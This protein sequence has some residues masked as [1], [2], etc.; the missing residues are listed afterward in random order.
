M[1]KRSRNEVTIRDVAAAAKVSM[2]T[3]SNVLNGRFGRMRVQTRQRVEHAM[4]VLRYRPHAVARNLRRSERLS[5]GLLFIDDDST[6]ITHPGHSHVVDGL[7]RYL[8]DRGY[9]LTLQGLNPA[10]LSEALPVRSV[11]TD[12]LCI[13]QSGPPARRMRTLVAL[14]GIAQPCV[15]IHENK[16]SVEGDFCQVREDD[17]A[18]GRL[19]AQHLIDRGCRNILMLLPTTIWASMEERA[20]GCK[21]I[22]NREKTTLSVLR[23][24]SSL[25]EQAQ[26]RLSA[27]LDGNEPPDG[28]IA[29]N[30]Q[31]GIAALRVLQARGLAVPA[32]VRV[33]GFNAFELWKYSN[34]RLTTIRTPAAALGVR[35]GEE[36]VR[37]LTSGSFT[38]KDI[39]LPV[40][41]VIGS[42]T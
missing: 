32:Q 29:G 15:L 36:L 24:P 38:K 27:Y 42:S 19:L 13:V 9:S 17:R 7:S 37:R 11:E 10:R 21:D 5:I 26:E 35:A 40:E 2:M 39:V 8:N 30:D 41:L 14:A 20:R 3:V 23:T 33:T 1:S 22:C 4:S 28:I 6:F 34:P 12:G 16:V 31:L 25:M 18:G